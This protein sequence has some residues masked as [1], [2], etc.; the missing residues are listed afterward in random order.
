MKMTELR[1]VSTHPDQTR[2]LEKSENETDA[3]LVT[4]EYEH[5]Q[6]IETIIAKLGLTRIYMYMYMQ[7]TCVPKVIKQA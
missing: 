7:Y 3:L 5:T 4:A 6:A 2:A 1:L